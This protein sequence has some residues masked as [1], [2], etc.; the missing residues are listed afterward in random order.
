MQTKP[1]S[2]C[3]DPLKIDRPRHYPKPKSSKK[4]KTKLAE[5][6]KSK[7]EICMHKASCENI[8]YSPSIFENDSV[9][10]FCNCG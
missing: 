1:C 4:V 3:R 2:L 10:N 5:I 9:P 7:I 8:C 6:L